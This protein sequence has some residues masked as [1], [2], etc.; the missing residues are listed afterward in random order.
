MNPFTTRPGRA[1]FALFAG[2]VLVATGCG[3]DDPTGPSTSTTTDASDYGSLLGVNRATVV[4]KTGRTARQS[5]LE[6][7]QGDVSFQVYGYD[8][9]LSSGGGSATG[10]IGVDRYPNPTGGFALILGSDGTVFGYYG[11]GSSGE[12]IP[13]ASGSINATDKTYLTPVKTFDK[14]VGPVTVHF[15]YRIGIASLN[16][17]LFTTTGGDSFTAALPSVMPWI[18]ITDASGPAAEIQ[19][20]VAQL[21]ADIAR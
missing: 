14:P 10:L 7:P 13:L 17:S 16:S 2:F 6:N 18:D 1:A 9:T 21:S 3:K 4:F 12:Q 11:S 15:N 8:A 20:A 19:A 5:K